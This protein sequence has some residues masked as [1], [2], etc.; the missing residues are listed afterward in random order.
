MTVL[1]SLDEARLRGPRLIH[2]VLKR[3]GTVVEVFGTSGEPLAALPLLGLSRGTVVP[4]RRAVG[5]TLPPGHYL[6]SGWARGGEDEPA[7]LEL[8]DL[9]LSTEARLVEAGSARRS[10]ASRLLDVRG[11]AAPT[12]GLRG[13]HDATEL[14]GGGL[15]VGRA[16]LLRLIDLLDADPARG[17]VVLTVAGEPQAVD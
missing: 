4:L 1:W 10:G 9:D 5:E 13:R 8:A 17:A 14:A 11:I 2:L 15:A 16:D 3:S 12:G 6:I 7:R